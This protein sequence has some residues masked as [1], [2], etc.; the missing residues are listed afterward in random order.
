[1]ASEKLASKW[2]TAPII[3][4][5][6][7]LLCRELIL[8]NEYLIENKILKSKI[9]KHISFTD[10][11]RRTL[12]TSFR[13]HSSIRGVSQYFAIQ[14]GFNAPHRSGREDFPHRLPT[15]WEWQAVADYDGSNSTGY[16]REWKQQWLIPYMNKMV[17]SDNSKILK[18]NIY[19]EGKMK[20]L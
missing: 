10:E 16:F 8:Q 7:R 17:S 18:Y 20:R 13:T 19:P 2:L 15:E 4:T 9:N 11:E 12:L 6:T 14:K 3:V 5:I 1:M